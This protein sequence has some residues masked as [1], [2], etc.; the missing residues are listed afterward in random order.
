[1]LPGVD[2]SLLDEPDAVDL[3]PHFP[4]T[5]SFDE[6]HMRALAKLY[7]IAYERGMTEQ[8]IWDRMPLAGE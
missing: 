8:Q 2:A 7:G 5:E 6:A 3:V 1:V 4:T